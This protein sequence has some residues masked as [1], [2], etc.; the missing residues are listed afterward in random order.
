MCC[1]STLYTWTFLYPKWDEIAYLRIWIL[2]PLCFHYTLKKLSHEFSLVNFNDPQ[3]CMMRPMNRPMNYFRFEFLKHRHLCICPL[4]AG[5]VII[6]NYPVDIVISFFLLFMLP[7]HND[8]YIVFSL[9]YYFHVDW[10]RISE[11]NWSPLIS[12]W[13]MVANFKSIYWMYVFCKNWW[14]AAVWASVVKDFLAYLFFASYLFAFFLFQTMNRGIAFLLF[15]TKSQLNIILCYIIRLMIHQ[16]ELCHQYL[17]IHEL[18]IK[19]YK[20]KFSPL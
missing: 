20:I 16:G 9:L 5:N 1:W 18:K 3:I 13:K 17:I 19:C 10:C 4:F 11:L 14:N 8:F 6:F 12:I 7:H 15:S 2:S